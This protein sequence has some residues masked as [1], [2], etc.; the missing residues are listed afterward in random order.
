MPRKRSSGEGALYK[1]KKRGLWVAVFDNG[2]TADG[3]R[4]QIRVTSKS[5]SEAREKMARKREEIEDGG[6]SSH[7][8]D[9][10]AVWSAYWLEHIQRPIMKPGPWRAYSY[11]LK[12]WISPAI[13]AIRSRMFARPTCAEST[14][15]SK[16]LAGP[17]PL[18]SRRT[19]SCHRCSKPRGSS[20][21]RR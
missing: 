8:N 19:W 17:T 13:G 5:Q 10:V 1:D 4:K 18:D 21:S 2:L 14:T 16:R 15:A 6:G 12:N 9:T 3:K 11:T 20:A 7:G